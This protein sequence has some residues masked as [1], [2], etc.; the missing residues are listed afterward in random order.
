MLSKLDA[1]LSYAKCYAM[2]TRAELGLDRPT[3]SMIL[4][5]LDKSSLARASKTVGVTPKEARLCIA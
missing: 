1:M 2:L 3:L 4:L 5:G